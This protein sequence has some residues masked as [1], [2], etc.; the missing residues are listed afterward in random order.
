MAGLRNRNAE[1]DRKI[2]AKYLRH[3]FGGMTFAEIDLAALMRW[4]D[5]QRA[6]G[7]ISEATIRRNLNLLSRFFGWAIDRGYTTDNPV[8]RIPPGK[9]PRQSGKVDAPWIE[10]DAPVRRVIARLREPI[11][12]MF[13]LGNRSGLRTGEIAGLRMSDL[14]FLGEGSIRVRYSY[15]GPLKEDKDGTGKVKWVPAAED[16]AEVLG[17][18]LARRRA[19]GA[20]PEDLVFVAPRGGCFGKVYLNRRWREASEECG[21][22]VTWYQGTR[23][24]F[25]SRNLSRGASLDEVSAAVGHSSPEVTKRYYD[26]FVRRSFS[27]KL[28]EGLGLAGGSQAPAELI[29]FPQT[30]GVQHNAHEPA[31]TP[32]AAVIRRPNP[33][34]S[35]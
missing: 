16:A 2:A 21:L 34:R 13:Y 9:R 31:T 25:V 28:R 15:D 4:I 7:Q 10:D 26:H 11:N 33:S 32:P 1:G 12:L 5:Q 24:S 3:T 29:P 27:Q 30:P 22:S 14:G 6:T 35:R 18:W 8:R 19:Q 23:H 17:P 20:A